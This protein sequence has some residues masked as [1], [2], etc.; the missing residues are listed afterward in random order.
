MQAQ[1]VIE[2]EEEHADV[3]VLDGFSQIGGIWSFT[4]GVFATVFGSTLLFELFGELISVNAPPQSVELN[5][6][7][8]QTTVGLWFGPLA[9]PRQSFLGRRKQVLFPRGA[10]PYC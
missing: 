3:S 7:R 4:Q 5:I 9:P 6:P 2:I 1:K 8:P 10:R